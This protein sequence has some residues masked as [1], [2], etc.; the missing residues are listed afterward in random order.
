MWYE[1]G[2]LP[3]L[4]FSRAAVSAYKLQKTA[5]SPRLLS[6]ALC[7]NSGALCGF[8]DLLHVRV[9]PTEWGDLIQQLIATKA[10]SSCYPQFSLCPFFP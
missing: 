8:S 3:L 2:K 5:T 10:G 4:G 9:K 7:K 1:T 6:A